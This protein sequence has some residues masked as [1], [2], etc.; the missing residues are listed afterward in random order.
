MQV[1]EKSAVRY[2]SVNFYRRFLHEWKIVKN[3]VY[4]ARK[5]GWIIGLTVSRCG[6]SGKPPVKFL[7][8]SNT[9]KRGGILGLT[10]SRCGNSGK[11]P[12]RFPPS[13][14]FRE[15][16]WNPR[17]DCFQVWKPSGN[18]IGVSSKW[19]LR[20]NYWCHDL[21]GFQRVPIIGKPLFSPSEV[22]QVLFHTYSY[23]W[24]E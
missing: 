1:C 16:R 14:Q 6:N 12:V 23:D 17:V 22:L 11:P 18:H 7:E 20:G 21:S 4:N 5:Q 9:R 13:F 2:V 24:T 3:K 10:V 15:S 19:K 8:V